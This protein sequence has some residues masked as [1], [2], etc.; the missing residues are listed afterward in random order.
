MKYL[1]A[2]RLQKI[3]WLKTSPVRVKWHCRDFHPDCY[4]VVC[5][6]YFH[7]ESMATMGLQFTGTGWNSFPSVKLQNGYMGYKTSPEPPLAKWWWNFSFGCTI[8]FK[9]H[10][11]KKKTFFALNQMV[12]EELPCVLAEG[13]SVIGW[14]AQLLFTVHFHF[15]CDSVSEPSHYGQR[16]L[17]VY[18]LAALIDFSFFL[19]FLSALCW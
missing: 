1:L 4:A 3:F 19:F 16:G 5:S 18:A 6:L 7:F 11:T 14:V 2:K 9:R 17:C 12:E 8:P 15:T 10:Q 13:L